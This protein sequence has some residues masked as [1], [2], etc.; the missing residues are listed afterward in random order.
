MLMVD[1]YKEW[2]KDEFTR[3]KDFVAYSANSNQLVYQHVVLQD[4]GELKDNILADFG[5]EVWED[6]Q[7]QFIDTSK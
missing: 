5:P 4:G 2:L 7:T 1:K 6:F 3:L